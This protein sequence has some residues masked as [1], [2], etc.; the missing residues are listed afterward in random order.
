MSVKWKENYK[1][2]HAEIDKQ[3]QHL[4]ELT[5][6]LMAANEPERLRPL[7]M[8]L[9]KHT[10][11]HFELEEN[12][13]R[14]LKFPDT[15]LHTGYHNKLLDRLNV[16]SQEVGQ[17]IVNK[18]AIEKLMRDWTLRHIPNDDAL[19]AAFVARQT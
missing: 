14:S 17:C 13:M 1:I 8:Q 16:I 10:R 6:A 4:F 5:H 11:E 12:L 19:L 7:I 18:P 2:G 9:Y 15:D 3:H